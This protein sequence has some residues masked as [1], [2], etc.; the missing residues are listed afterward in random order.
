MTMGRYKVALPAAFI[1][2]IG[3]A[4]LVPDSTQL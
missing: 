3:T 2:A 1:L 4:S